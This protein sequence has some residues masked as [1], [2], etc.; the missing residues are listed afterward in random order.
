MIMNLRLKES[1]GAQ[2]IHQHK[3][4]L[5]PL[6]TWHPPMIL[7]KFMPNYDKQPLCGDFLVAYQTSYLLIFLKTPQKT[8]TSGETVSLIFNVFCI[9]Q[10][11]RYF[12]EIFVYGIY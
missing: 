7:Y 6:D 12:V 8:S 5:F 4:N 10:P 9:F 3:L 1:T 11:L 2:G